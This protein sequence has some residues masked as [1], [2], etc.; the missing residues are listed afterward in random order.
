MEYSIYILDCIHEYNNN[1]KF[2]SCTPI[3]SKQTEHGN[4]EL[5]GEINSEFT[6]LISLSRIGAK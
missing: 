6:T 4:Y 5:L 2:Q 3:V 1:K